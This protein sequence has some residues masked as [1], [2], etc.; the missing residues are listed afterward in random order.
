[1]INDLSIVTLSHLKIK[2]DVNLGARTSTAITK[3]EFQQNIK[4]FIC[5]RSPDEHREKVRMQRSLNTLY[6]TTSN[7]M[8]FQKVSKRSCN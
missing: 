3:V 8:F 5:H 4:C 7:H 6:A 1:M 2:R